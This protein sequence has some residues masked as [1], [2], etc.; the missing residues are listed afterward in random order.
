MA[1]SQS[2]RSVHSVAERLKLDAIMLG[3]EQKD[4]LVELYEMQYRGTIAE[5][6]SLRI[7]QLEQSIH[8]KQKL[9]DRVMGIR[10]RRRPR[11]PVAVLQQE[12]V[13]RAKNAV[14]VWEIL[15]STPM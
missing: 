11:K 4:L 12:R 6:L 8:V 3:E 7:A 13:E 15:N 5:A 14:A 2:V 10:V 1:Q 9:A